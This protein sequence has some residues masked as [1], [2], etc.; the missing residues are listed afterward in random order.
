MADPKKYWIGPG[1]LRVDKKISVPNGGELT[2]Q[3]MEKLGKDR[4]AELIKDG[5]VGEKVVAISAAGRPSKE[6]T[7]LKTLIEA[8]DKAIEELTAEIADLKAA[9]GG[10]DK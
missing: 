5:L 10:G 2:K 3:V 8:K 7:A 6:V 9:A 1:T 4:L